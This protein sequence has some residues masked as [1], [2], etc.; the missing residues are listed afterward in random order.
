MYIIGEIYKFN[1]SPE[2]WYCLLSKIFDELKENNREA[3]E[4]NEKK[5]FALKL[6]IYREKYHLT[7]DELAEKIGTTRRQII[8]W[9]S[10]E[11]RPNLFTQ[12]VLRERQIV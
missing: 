8:R 1:P 9:E 7:Q 2:G 10:E 6:K 5:N 4:K 3:W 11:S 12:K